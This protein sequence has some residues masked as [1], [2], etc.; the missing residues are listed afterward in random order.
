MLIHR[1]E[2]ILDLKELTAQVQELVAKVGFKSNQIICQGRTTDVE[3]WHLGVGR[4]YELEHKNE[5]EYTNIFPS[6]AGT[7]LEKYIKRYNGFRTRIMTVP[8]RHC[9]SVH[10]DPSPR[11]HIPLITNKECWMVWPYD[12]E[13][14]KMPAQFSY[15]ADTTK[16]HTFLNGGEE[17]R[18]HI[19][20]CINDTTPDSVIS[21]L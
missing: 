10:R 11:I 16:H 4:I 18:I 2:P 5:D 12:K 17:D 8:P 15:W 9:Y 7:V 3:D 13:N 1:I 20:M 19:V 21:K 6:L 14:V